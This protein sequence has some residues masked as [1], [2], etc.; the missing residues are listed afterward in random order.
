MIS[1]FG[2][3]RQISGMDLRELRSRHRLEPRRVSQAIERLSYINR[4]SRRGR[5]VTK[6][7]GDSRTG[8]HG[9]IYKPLLVLQFSATVETECRERKRCQQRIRSPAQSGAST[10]LRIG[11][12]DVCSVKIRNNM[13]TVARYTIHDTRNVMMVMTMSLML[14]SLNNREI[15]NNRGRGKKVNENCERKK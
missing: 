4:H 5:I 7:N 6:R 1:S 10:F 9:L 2:R 3:S 14:Q 12:L 15:S 11:C 8:K 13:E